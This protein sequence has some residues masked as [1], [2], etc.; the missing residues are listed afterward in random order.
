MRLLKKIILYP[1]VLILTIYH[2]VKVNQI[3]SKVRGAKNKPVFCSFRKTFQDVL[4]NE[5]KKDKE[6]I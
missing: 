2:W 6:A 4:I 5:L 3:I 1:K